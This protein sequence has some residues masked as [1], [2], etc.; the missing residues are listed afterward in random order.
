MSGINPLDNLIAQMQK[1]LDYNLDRAET[2]KNLMTE[3]LLEVA[4]AREILEIL[5]EA[6]RGH[7]R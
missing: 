7:N 5:K 1:K 4:N 6:Q 2:Y 3:V